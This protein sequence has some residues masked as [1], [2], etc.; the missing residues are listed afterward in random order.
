MG[1][2][3]SLVL[4]FL[5]IVVF[6]S[7]ANAEQTLR[8]ETTID[9]AKRTAGQSNRLVLIVFTAPWCQACRAMESE[10]LSQ[11]GVNLALE[12]NY[13]PVKVNVEYFPA[14]ARQYGITALPTTVVIAPTSQGEVLDSIR[15]RMAASPYLARLDQVA[16]DAK[17]RGVGVV[18][19]IPGG[20]APSAADRSSPPATAPGN[21]R[22]SADANSDDRYANASDRPVSQP[23]SATVGM[24]IGPS[25]PQSPGPA[26]P[27]AAAQA[28]SFSSGSNSGLSAVDRAA[29]AAEANVLRQTLPPVAVPPA[30]GAAPG[31]S[32]IVGSGASPVGAGGL[33]VMAA[34][35]S[36]PPSQQQQPAVNPSPAGNP[37]IGL[38]GFCPVRLNERSVWTPGDRRWGAIH[39]GQTYLFVGPD[40][41]RRFLSEPDRYSPVSSGLDVVVA[42]EQGRSI[43]GN[44]SHGVFFGGKVYLFA[45]EVSLD[46]F[47]KN[48]KY[49]A[50]RALQASRSPADLAPQMR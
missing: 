34:G 11:P 20:P 41:Q 46:K 1:K 24:P 9:G 44:R 48:P 50:D 7:G 25:S 47:S 13:V 19:Q 38:D 4:A 3:R 29:T 18:A 30:Q 33:P 39:R 6:A 49:Y 16:M 15:G 10:V 31:V 21:R 2:A 45:D 27:P 23:A 17:R 26:A 14:A 22:A 8:W 5:G 32:S 36:N 28:G 37:P 40:E 43:A 12:A 35:A 42:L